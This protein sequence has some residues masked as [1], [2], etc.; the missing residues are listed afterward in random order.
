MRKLEGRKFKEIIED[1]KAMMDGKIDLTVWLS[2]KASIGRKDK[3][4]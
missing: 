2:E 1:M 3:N 4:D